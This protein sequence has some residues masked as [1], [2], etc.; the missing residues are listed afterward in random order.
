M[1][2]AQL[3]N[4]N[5]A[6]YARLCGGEGFRVE[7]AADLAPA[8]KEAL[9]QKTPSLVEIIADPLLTQQ[10]VAGTPKAQ[11]ASAA[12]RRET[13]HCMR[14][15][16]HLGPQARIPVSGPATVHSRDGSSLYA[17]RSLPPDPTRSYPH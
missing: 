9:T 10:P 15:T 14:F 13:G 4:V 1:W 17:Y 6:D 11:T 8:L 16:P 2:Q 5:F 12:R 3:H 7:K